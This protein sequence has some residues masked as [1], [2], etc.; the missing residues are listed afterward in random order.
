MASADSLAAREPLFSDAAASKE[1]W[2]ACVTRPLPVPSLSDDVSSPSDSW[3]SDSSPLAAP[4]A[5]P[6]SSLYSS[7]SSSSSSSSNSCSPNA[8][9][10]SSSSSS[11]SSW[12][13]SRSGRFSSARVA[14]RASEDALREGRRRGG[15]VTSMTSS[16]SSSTSPFAAF[17]S[18]LA[19]R[20]TSTASGL[21]FDSSALT[22]VSLSFFASM[23]S[24]SRFIVSHWT[25]LSRPGSSCRSILE[26]STIF[27]SSPSPSSV[28]VR[29]TYRVPPVEPPLPQEMPKMSLSDTKSGGFANS[30][31]SLSGHRCPSFTPWKQLTYDAPVRTDAKTDS[32]STSMGTDVT[33]CS[34]LEITSL[35]FP[36]NFAG[37]IEDS[38]VLSISQNPLRSAE[39]RTTGSSFPPWT[40]FGAGSKPSTK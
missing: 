1:P 33:V 39:M 24:A 32:S 18:G 4:K 8:K 28:S 30:S 22:L 19:T 40:G 38:K 10:S 17:P 26:N 34:R 15:G 31:P 23:F 37:K 3:K 5:S 29:S 13:S 25:Y 7:A 14:S 21:T 16:S 11:S 20:V 35:G 27:S 9:S 2:P 6:P 12:S 36:V